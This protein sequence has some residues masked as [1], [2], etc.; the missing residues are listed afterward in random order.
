MRSAIQPFP[1]APR[2]MEGELLSSWRARIACRYGLKGWELAPDILS[3]RH[4]E[5]A[6][7][8]DIDWAPTP[9]DIRFLAASSRL[10]VES[11][12]AMTLARRGWPRHWV[13]WE[14][15]P[16]DATPWGP[17]GRVEVAWCPA[18]LRQD[19]QAG[20]DVWLRRDWAIA[21]RGLCAMH[22]LPLEQ[23]CHFC[24]SWQPQRWA[25]LE[26]FAVLLCGHCGRS[27]DELAS[28]KGPRGGGGLTRPCA[29]HDWAKLRAFE[30]HLVAVLDG[31]E[32]DDYW[33]GPSSRHA[34]LNFV[35]D[36]VRLC[37]HINLNRGGDWTLIERIV[38]PP[39]PVRWRDQLRCTSAYPLAVVSVWW[40]RA[41]LSAVARLLTESSSE[42]GY[43]FSWLEEV[44]TPQPLN[45]LRFYKGLEFRAFNLTHILR[46]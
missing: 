27:L 19:R 24:G 28:D 34:F 17:Y 7:Q 26:G 43:G 31:H 36:L 39:W 40:R 38:L 30:E 3:S 21:A 37:C 32:P 16:D 4:S 20:R 5:G 44:L 1:L 12:A 9:E 23:R 25:L 13:C 46:A 11:V 29:P 8:R 22:G 42:C 18:C 33:A 35:E 10:D 14:R 2:P 15:A 6:F 45:V 41:L